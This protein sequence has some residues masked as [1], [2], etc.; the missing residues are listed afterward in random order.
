MNAPRTY[1]TEFPDFDAPADC[2]ALLA[3]G[4]R[5]QSWHN[6]TCPSFEYGGRVAMFVD[7]AAPELRE[8]PELSDGRFT[9]I[10][11]DSE[12]CYSDEC[13][14]L[15]NLSEAMAIAAD[16]ADEMAGDA[17]SLSEF[18]RSLRFKAQCMTVAD[19]RAIM[20]EN[21]RAGRPCPDLRAHCL[22]IIARHNS[23]PQ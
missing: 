18:G 17:G 6:D 15:S 20:A 23:A 16:M 3:A 22:D 8:S 12:G 21:D 5:D 1:Q 19:A 11:L 14:T 7:Y 13:A 2:A 10:L 9:V 4:W